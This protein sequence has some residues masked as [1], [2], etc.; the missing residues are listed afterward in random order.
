MLRA[1]GA[2][3]L[4]CT[5]ALVVARIVMLRRQGIA[6]MKFGA[7]DKSDF[8]IPPFAFFYLYV[9]FA[10]AFA[11]PTVAHGLLFRS[12]AAAWTGAVLCA[13]AFVL[14]IATLVSFGA[15]FRVGIDTQ[16]PDDLVTTGTFAISRNPIYVAFAMML[17]GEFLLQPHWIL[18]LYALAGFGLLRRQV[19]REEAYLEQRYGHEFRAYRERVRRYL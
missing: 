17:A 5:I 19:L 11:W 6:A 7:T 16:Q 18:L 15:S 10:G 9:V 14:M 12:A 2:I 3:A 4:A 13:G 1:V 8:V